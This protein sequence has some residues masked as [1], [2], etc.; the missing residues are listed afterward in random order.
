MLT[1][2]M[3]RV[4][5]ETP[6]ITY[7]PSAPLIAERE[8]PATKTLTPGSGALVSDAVTTP[9]TVAVLSC[10]WRTMGIQS[11]AKRKAEVL[12]QLIMNSPERSGRGGLG[13]VR[14]NNK[15]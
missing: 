7:R 1:A 3:T 8:E 9:A 15:F 13:F 12:R 14:K 4:P 11:R 5:G 6:V 2:R 10:A